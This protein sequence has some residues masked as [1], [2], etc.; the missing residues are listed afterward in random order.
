M[1]SSCFSCCPNSSLMSG[2]LICYILVPRMPG[3]SQ[4][5]VCGPL[6]G[7]QRPRRPRYSAA[8]YSAGR[9]SSSGTLGLSQA[10]HLSCNFPR[11]EMEGCVWRISELGFW[12]C[13]CACL[14]SLLKSVLPPPGGFLFEGLSDDEDDFHPVSGLAACPL[15]HVV[16]GGLIPG[17]WSP[18]CELVIG[19]LVAKS[20]PH[21]CF[22]TLAA[23]GGSP[24][25]VH[26]TGV[27]LLGTVTGP[28]S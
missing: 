9:G 1:I 2:T 14:S 16:Q 28:L 11:A 18:S 26:G 3:E 21:Y 22:L 5:S 4:E 12:S 25:S 10:V 13:T 7:W 8:M 27:G 20:M 15:E 19:P 17:A 24:R 23:W 6:G